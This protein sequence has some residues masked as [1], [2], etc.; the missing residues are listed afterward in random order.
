MLLL[1]SAE[2]ESSSRLFLRLKLIKSAC[3]RRGAAEGCAASLEVESFEKEPLLLNAFFICLI[4][5]GPFLKTL[6]RLNFK[7]E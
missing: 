4:K 2:T 3:C 7:Y 1:R 5:F 6:Y